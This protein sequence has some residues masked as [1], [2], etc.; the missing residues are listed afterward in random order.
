MLRGLAALESTDWSRLLHAYGRATDTPGHLRAL[1]Q[2]DPGPRKA[3]L[4]HLFSAIIHQGTPWTATGPVAL[5]VAGFLSDERIDRGE[6]IRS[7]LLSFLVS[8]AEAP[9]QV[10][11]SFEELESMAAFDIEPFLDAEDPWEQF[12][13]T[14]MNSSYAR[15]I[16]ECVRVAPVIL[17]A[18]L[19]E[20][21][22]S[23]PRVRARAAMGASTLA[24]TESLRDYSGG[25]QYRLT[26]M[27]R[28]AGDIDERCS[29]VLALGELGVS[30]IEFLAD[31]SPPVRMCAA[32]A[33]ALAD[34][35]AT[36]D[37]LLG[38]LEGEAGNIDDWFVEKPPQ[39]PMRPRFRVIA[40]LTEQVKDFDR[41]VNAAIAVVGQTDKRLVDLDWGPF[42][43][44]AFSDGTGVIRTESQRRFL[45]ALAQ[46]AELWDPR[47][48]N[49]DKWFK[50]AGLPR[51]RDACAKLL[52][53]A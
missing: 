33:P 8:V 50:R 47:I 13:E 37:E 31:D 39:F 5:V 48:G 26:S 29:H 30:P 14:A 7:A 28:S 3:A 15:S 44:A 27:A 35:D 49:A 36:L 11:L 25:I 51:D 52:E 34:D 20:L 2:P 19:D 4:N 46:N 53:R 10:G 21:S 23:D 18:M 22:N 17:M 16:L 32:L 9:E 45:R 40:R 38:A 24:K 6:S 41:L 43:A 42:L 12:D 1:L